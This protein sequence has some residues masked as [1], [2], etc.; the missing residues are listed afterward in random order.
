MP[1]AMGLAVKMAEKGYLSTE[2]A[3]ERIG[4][5]VSSV[6]R[7]CATSRVRSERI[8]RSWWVQKESLIQYLGGT[9]SVRAL[10]ESEEA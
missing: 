10:F 7:L 5:A 4:F 1:R 9:E 2:T 3:A 6:T 8:G